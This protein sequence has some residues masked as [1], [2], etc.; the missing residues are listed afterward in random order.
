MTRRKTL[1]AVLVVFS[2]A[3]GGH[4]QAEM[5][6]SVNITPEGVAIGGWDTVAYFTENRAVMGSAEF[7]HDWQGAAWHFAS[8]AN[9]DL[10]AGDPEAYAPQFGGWCAYALSKGQYAAEVDPQQAWTVHEN[11][12]F[13]NWNAKIRKKWVN[14]G[15]E[16]GVAV[17]RENWVE[18]E[19]QILDG[20]AEYSRKGN[21]PWNGL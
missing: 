15:I 10:F 3:V 8:A 11:Q 20:D 18:V 17:G 5:Q 4:V 16:E 21:S 13:L 1:S 6:T 14:S 9:R 7:S 2:L 12:L 19:Q